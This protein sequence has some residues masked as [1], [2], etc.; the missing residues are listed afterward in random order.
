MNEDINNLTQ[1]FNEIKKSGWV[2]SQYKGSASIGRT[3]ELLIG[4]EPESF[5]IPDFEEIEIKTR[6]KYSNYHTTLFNAVPDSYL[7]EV[8]RIRQTYGYPDKI[9]KQAKVLKGYVYANKKTYLGIKYQ[10]QLNINYE[11][12]L[13]VLNVYN[14]NNKLI[15]NKTSWSFTLL[16]EK[17]FQKLKLLAVINT[18][19]K[20]INNEKYFKYET[21]EMFKLSNFENFLKLIE[22]GKIV[23]SFTIGVHRS[24]TKIGQPENHGVA[25]RLKYE[26]FDKLFTKIKKG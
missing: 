4:K 19:K 26:D 24:G 1:K 15:D 20:I 9:I 10:F 6:Y 7:F 8:N 16:K 22:K 2:K 18:D 11:K 25:F 3:F 5:P 23:V 14:R 12:E 13:L 21:M 17:L